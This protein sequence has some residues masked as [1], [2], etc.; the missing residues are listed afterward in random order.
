[1]IEL[2]Y[3]KTSDGLSVV[4]TRTCYNEIR[5]GHLVGTR[6]EHPANETG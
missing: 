4:L 5:P 3:I 1:M 6:S 2:D